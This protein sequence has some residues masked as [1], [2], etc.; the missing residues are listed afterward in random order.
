MPPPLAAATAS[1]EVRSNAALRWQYRPG[2]ALFLVWSQ[3][4]THDGEATGFEPAPQARALFRREGTNVFLI[5][6][7]HWL[8]R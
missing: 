4:R 6:V 1:P 2:S 8:G 7:S 5:K 3:E